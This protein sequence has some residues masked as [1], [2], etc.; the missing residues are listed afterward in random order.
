MTVAP[1]YQTPPSN[2]LPSGD[3]LVEHAESLRASGHL[4]EAEA[5]LRDAITISPDNVAAYRALWLLLVDASR[6]SEAFATCG[7][8]L[9]HAGHADGETLRL[10]AEI[11]LFL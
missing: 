2:S 5:A 8:M 6:D 1:S 11:L 4:A 7:A 10:A 3:A 9:A